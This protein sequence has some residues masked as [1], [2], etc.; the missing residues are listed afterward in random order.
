MYYMKILFVGNSHT[1]NYEVPGLMLNIAKKE[2]IDCFAAMNAHGGWT[3]SQHTR[4]PDVPFNIKN[5][6]YDY[7]VLQEHAH[8]F[9]YDGKMMEAIPLLKQWAD[10]GGAKTV[11]FVP[12]AQKHERFKQPEMTAACYEAARIYD[13][14]VAPIGELWWEYQDANPEVEMYSPDRGHA[15]LIGAEF[16]AKVIWDT[17]MED[18]KNK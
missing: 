17:I 11:I 10:E 1:F 13:C 9:D 7:V 5:G 4:E 15:S 18:Y 16:A 3:L 12:W 6:G 2:G 14:L 8:P